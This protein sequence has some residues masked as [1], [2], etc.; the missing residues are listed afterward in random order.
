M[1]MA[2]FS[3]RKPLGAMGGVIVLALLIMALLASVFAPYDPRQII[4]EANHRVPVYVPPGHAY[5]LGTDHIG[6]DILSR[7]IYGARVSLYVGSGAVVIGVTGWFVVG[8]VTAYAG[9]T[10]RP[11]H[12][13]HRGRHDGRPWPDYRAGHYGCVAGPSLNNV[14]IAIVIGM[15][16]PWC[17][18]FGPRYY[19]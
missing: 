1:A 2:R 15:L 6:R 9:G 17:A 13:A 8:M 14:I 3:T 12:A 10:V 18:P 16:A 5:L 11:H 4:R 19:Q 7:I